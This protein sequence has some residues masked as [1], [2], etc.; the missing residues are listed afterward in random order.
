[1]QLDKK[2]MCNCAKKDRV[3]YVR[4]G[5]VVGGAAINTVGLICSIILLVYF[6]YEP[7]NY[8]AL[9]VAAVTPAYNLI[10]FYRKYSKLKKAGHSSKCAK[11]LSIAKLLDSYVVAG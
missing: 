7:R 1:M 8:L 4:L 5:G 6:V 10:Y 9:L 11:K 2:I 3:N